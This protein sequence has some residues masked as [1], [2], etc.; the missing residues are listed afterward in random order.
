MN[1]DASELEGTE[2]SVLRALSARLGVSEPSRI[3]GAA[4]ADLGLWIDLITSAGTPHRVLIQD[5]QSAREAFVRS[6]HLAFSL[7]GSG[8]APAAEALG[9]AVAARCAK[10]TW[11]EVKAAVPPASGRDAPRG[12]AAEAPPPERPGEAVSVGVTP[13][14]PASAATNTEVG[15]LPRMFGMLGPT[16][17]GRGRRL[18]AAEWR[19]ERM[20]VEIETPG[21]PAASLF[22][23][24]LR[25]DRPSYRRTPHLA[26]SYENRVFTPA[27][28]GVIDAFITA[29]GSITL[30]DLRE[31]LPPAMH[32]AAGDGNDAEPGTFS[33][34][35]SVSRQWRGKEQWHR[36]FASRELDR[37]VQSALKLATRFI[38]VE[39]GDRECGFAKLIT[40]H[41]VPSFVDYPW[42]REPDPHDATEADV[43]P[44]TYTTDMDES[45]AVM[46]GLVKLERLLEGVRN[47]HRGEKVRVN[48]CCLPMVIGDDY[49]PV[50]D[51]FSEEHDQPVVFTT[52]ETHE[53]VHGYAGVLVIPFEGRG[54]AADGI[55]LV[56]YGDGRDALE[57]EDLLRAA[58]IRPNVR[59]L[60]DATDAR[61][62]GYANACAQVFLPVAPWRSLYTSV[63]RK[64]PLRS[65]EAPPPFGLEGTSAWLSVVG[66]G[67]GVAADTQRVL[68]AARVSLSPAWEALRAE[69]SGQR[70]GFVLDRSELR[71]LLDAERM[72]GVALLP[73][74]DEMG[75]GID[76]LCFDGEFPCERLAR[77]A[78]EALPRHSL[79]RV[80]SFR[81]PASLAA[82]LRRSE[83]FAF[84]TEYRFDPRLTRAGKAQFSCATF[85]KGLH[86][87]LRSLRR[88]LDLARL[89][90][91]RRYAEHLTP[92]A[93]ALTPA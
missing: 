91:Y 75:F 23:E 13:D 36:F 49:E 12:G 62:E 22:L 60:P 71:R 1:Q 74:L 92:R 38:E 55:N 6:T 42:R 24:A 21:A 39:H 72:M 70:V 44:V 78:L 90:F 5:T 33:A 3:A 52:Q 73:L 61:L 67:L 20:L 88:M 86:G 41:P 84:Y 10:L 35:D 4:W 53:P 40:R 7:D 65:I 66:E 9:R 43:T 25:E 18:A 54:P 63:F 11:A 87:A 76:L 31:A 81:D 28:A 85:E 64:L 82:A 2:A 83:A 45:D 27:L 77:N 29:L 37:N 56:G 79:H 57:L 26:I 48:V 89:P 93:R 8:P 50:I 14:S 16:D 47:K 32:F 34:N 80:E 68:D 19:D 51:R 69:A 59:V 15:A 30:D 58:V 46:G 17:R